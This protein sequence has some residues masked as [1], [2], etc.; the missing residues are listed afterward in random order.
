[1]LNWQLNWR[2]GM[3]DETR[4]PIRRGQGLRL[5]VPSQAEVGE[6]SP[7]SNEIVRGQGLRL[8]TTQATVQTAVVRT[9][10]GPLYYRRVGEGVPLIAIHG[11][12]ASGQ[13]WRDV[14][15]G[16]A[17]IRTGYAIDLPGCGGSPARGE[18]PTLATLADEVV[19]FANAMGLRRFDL[20]GHGLGAGVAA[21]VAATQP[22][23]VGK[24]ILVSFGV[25]P[26]TPDV[27]TLAVVRTPI[28][29]F[30]GLARPM[31]NTWAGWAVGMPAID[32]LMAAWLMA[33]P[34]ADPVLWEAYL[35]DH[36]RADGRMYLTMQTMAA[37]PLLRR[38]LQTINAPTLLIGGE[39]DRLVRPAELAAV[40]TLIATARRELIPACGHLPPIEH[41]NEC[42]RLIRSW[43]G[44]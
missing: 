41:P 6:T 1:M 29:L 38:R 39:A 35:A 27:L 30:L 14:L 13:L 26:G 44:E 40:Q 17:D 9:A 10:N 4:G 11:V 36:G 16:L 7:S 31:I 34:P 43:L 42:R 32:Q 33:G 15:I 24:L 8:S 5:S 18:A 21:T 2:N 12:G 22:A 37:D 3:A 25:R 28:D 19:A 23:R 20:M